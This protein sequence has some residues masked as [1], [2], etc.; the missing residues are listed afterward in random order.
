MSL[1][2]Y[3]LQEIPDLEVMP[4]GEHQ[5]RCV[6]AEEGTS[7]KSGDPYILLRLEIVGEPNVKQITNPIM[8]P[9]ENSDERE[10]NSRLR[11]LK[12][13]VEAFSLDPTNVDTEDFEGKTAWA[14][15]TEESDPEYGDQN[16]VRRFISGQ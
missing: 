15:L 11:R 7:N 8:L 10:T 4:E 16:N 2:D 14:F 13:A 5:V 6:R 9:G 3:N 12:Q 1:L